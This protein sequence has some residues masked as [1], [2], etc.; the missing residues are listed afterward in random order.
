[1]ADGFGQDA[2]QRGFRGAAIVIADPA[3]ELEDSGSDEGLPAEDFEDGFQPCVSRLLDQSSDAAQH[4][5]R[6]ERDLDAAAD[7]NLV[8]QLG[9]NGRA[10][11]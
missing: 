11:V 5:P 7:V 10:P 3:G 8:R 1:M 2:F 6:A 4:F 9:R